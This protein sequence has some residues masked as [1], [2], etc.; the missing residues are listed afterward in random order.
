MRLYKVESDRERDVHIHWTNPQDY[1]RILEYP[2]EKYA[3]AYFYKILAKSPVNGSYKLI[4]IGKTERYVIQRLKEHI[5]KIEQ[6]QDDYKRHHIMVSLGTPDYVP[7]N[8]ST[9]IDQVESLLIYAHADGAYFENQKSIWSYNIKDAYKITN[10]GFRK[11]GMH[12]EIHLG[13]F[14]R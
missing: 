5:S 2:K 13:V 10:S 4:Y 14:F 7:Q 12:K 8:V 3:E 1:Y 11:D 6:I 9:F